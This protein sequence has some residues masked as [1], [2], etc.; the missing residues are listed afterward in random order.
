M[1]IANLSSLV[2]AGKVIRPH[3]KTTTRTTVAGGWF[4]MYDVAGNPGAGTLAG[5][6]T[7]PAA[8]SAGRIQEPTLAGSAYPSIPWSS[9][10]TYISRL[11]LSNTVVSQIALYD[12]IWASGAYSF[13]ANTAVTSP[14]WS[15]RVSYN[16]GSADYH[17]LEIWAETVTAATGNQTWNVTY[18]DQDGNTGATTGA[19]GIGAAPT[20]GRCWQLPLAAGDSGLQAVSNVAGGTGSAGTAN[21]LVLRPLMRV[22]IP[23][24]NQTIVL[25][26]G[27]LGFPE[28]FNTTAL[29]WMSMAPSGT[30][31]GAPWVE[32]QLANG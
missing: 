26:Y 5:H 32:Y 6:E 24:A 16:G 21:I 3:Y 4:S 9:N 22:H 7:T 27:D 8:T 2:G 10:S 15:A 25:N 17:G 19:V 14:S 28:I 29:F 31:S 23:V 13:N 12:C 20:V 18:T 11:T 1:A 30:S